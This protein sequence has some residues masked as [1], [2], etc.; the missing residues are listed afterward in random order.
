M[1][2][3]WISSFYICRRGGIGRHIRLKIWGLY[4]REGS[5]PSSG[6]KIPCSRIPSR[7]QKAPALPV[8]RVARSNGFTLHLYFNLVNG[9]GRDTEDDN[10]DFH[11]HGSRRIYCY[12]N[13]SKAGI[14]TD[15]QVQPWGLSPRPPFYICRKSVHGGT[16]A[17]QAERASSILVSDSKRINDILRDAIRFYICPFSSTGQS[18]RLIIVRT[19]FESP[20]GHH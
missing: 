16:S 5:S 14:R 3:S 7:T 2:F 10:L 8:W 9:M 12:W 11:L 17:F 1:K 15:F 4:W 13:R 19:E 6:T 20:S 18:R